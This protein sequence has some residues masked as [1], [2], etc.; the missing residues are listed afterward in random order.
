NWQPYSG[1]PSILK[2]PE[3]LV[4]SVDGEWAIALT[5]VEDIA[6]PLY[7]GVMIHQFNSSVKGWKSGTG[8]QA[9]WEE[10]PLALKT[11]EPQ[12]L[13]SSTNYQNSPKTTRNW[14]VGYRRIARTTD[15]RTWIGSLISDLPAGDSIFY[16]LSN[17]DKPVN[18]LVLIAILN[19]FVYDWQLRNRLG[20]TNLSWFILEETACIRK[21][22]ATENCIHDICLRLIGTTLRHATE[23]KIQAS[24]SNDLT[25][26][27]WYCLWA[28]TPCERLRLRCILDALIAE[29]YGLDF[30]SFKWILSDCDYPVQAYQ[31]S[32]CLS[33]FD[34]KGFWRVDKEKDPELRHTVLSLV[35]F[36]Q[37]KQIGLDAFL[38]LNDG[39]G[40]M[41]PDTLRLADYGLGHDDRAKEPQ[42]V[43]ARLGDRFLPWQ[44][45][46]TPA[47]SWEEC[48]R[49]AETLRRLLGDPWPAK[50]NDLQ[51]PL[52]LSVL[53]D[54]W[55]K[56][57]GEP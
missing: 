37:L 36:H 39:E 6:L 41:L 50:G 12:Y 27:N 31:D 43:A 34:P 49:H 17:P 14:K 22:K 10:L 19:S 13:V 11:L 8:A 55:G 33:R 2:R 35:A 48:E 20:G 30:D 54:N 53:P 23:W 28:A 5:E 25:K 44:L 46:G 7:Q 51:S 29:L 1:E 45:A 57:A 56:S 21:D 18:S 4:L 32:K 15:T 24:L 40:W 47:E 26:K 16:L 38:N 42:P 52:Q 3:G 9:L